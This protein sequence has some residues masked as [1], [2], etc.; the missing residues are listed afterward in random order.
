MRCGR[1]ACGAMT[2]QGK[3]SSDVVVNSCAVCT[4]RRRGDAGSIDG[5]RPPCGWPEKEGDCLGALVT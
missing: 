3:G 5:V 4:R 2:S 1:E